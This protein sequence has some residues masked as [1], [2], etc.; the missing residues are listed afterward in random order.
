MASDARTQ[1]TN[2]VESLV[3][4]DWVTTSDVITLRS[5]LIISDDQVDHAL[6]VLSELNQNLQEIDSEYAL[7]EKAIFDS[8]LVKITDFKR[9][10]ERLDLTIREETSESADETQET[11]LL[12]QLNQ[13]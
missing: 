12:T 1:I 3:S 4:K 6:D 7:K 11:N 2:I 10:T 13:I 5:F 9:Q 8:Y